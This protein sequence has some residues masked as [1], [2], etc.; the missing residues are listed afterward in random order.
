[1][2]IVAIPTRKVIEFCGRAT[3]TESREARHARDPKN[4][5][6]GIRLDWGSQ[7]PPARHGPARYQLVI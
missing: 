1:L 4:T 6:M 3:G 5:D 2:L 7:G